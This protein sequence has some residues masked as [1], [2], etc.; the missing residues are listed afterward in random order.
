MIYVRD[1]EMKQE[2]MY[3]IQRIKA[4]FAADVTIKIMEK[5]NFIITTKDIEEIA[6][7]AKSLVLLVFNEQC[8][9]KLD[10]IF[11]PNQNELK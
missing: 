6:F 2:Q 8:N 4:Q 3:A 10:G 11:E 9:E 1:E 5:Y 7:N